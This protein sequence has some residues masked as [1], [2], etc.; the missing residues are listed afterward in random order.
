MNLREPLIMEINNPILTEK[1]EIVIIVIIKELGIYKKIAKGRINLHQSHILNEQLFVEKYVSLELYPSQ[2]EKAIKDHIGTDILATIS[3]IGKVFMKAQIFDPQKE[4]DPLKQMKLKEDT[5]QIFT[6]S[7]EINGLTKHIKKQIKKFRDE[8]PEL[9]K[10][11][12]SSK[13]EPA[14]YKT[15]AD[16]YSRDFKEK[17]FKGNTG[18]GAT[19]KIHEEENNN[20]EENFN[21]DDLEDNHFND[22]LSNASEELEKDKVL[23]QNEAALDTGILQ[24]LM[25]VNCELDEIVNKLISVYQE[26]N[27]EK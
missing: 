2:A 25:F 18:S 15:L 3:N 8:N 19:I 13:L 11:I 4:S 20:P 1:T 14:R 12:Q 6:S 16:K 24:N 5:K 17:R 9:I 26:K 10:N 7:N 23:I 27:D 22:G 21:L